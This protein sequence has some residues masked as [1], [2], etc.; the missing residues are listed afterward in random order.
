MTTTLDYYNQNAESFVSGTLDAG[1]TVTQD[2]FLTYIPEGG[3]ILDF[4][5]GS[6]RDAK[7]FLTKGYDVEATDGSESL[8][9]IASENAGIE[10]RKMLFSELDEYERYDGI[11]ACASILHLTK[12]ELRDVIPKMIRAVKPGGYIYTSFKYGD[13]EG[14]RGDRFFK[15]FTEDSFNE[16]ITDYSGIQIVE[17]WITSDVR[18][19]RG[20]EKWL[21]IILQ[22]SVT[23]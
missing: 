1:F 5:C 20:D 16:F 7:Y 4:G 17:E 12:D 3:K 2:Q 22:K 10:V 23:D 9:K 19:G 21:N 15:Y 11:W 8:C 6:G 14:Y 18:P 13:F